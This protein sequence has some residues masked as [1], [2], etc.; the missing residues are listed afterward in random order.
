MKCLICYSTTDIK[1][2]LTTL[3][4]TIINGVD[5]EDCYN[6]VINNPYWNRADYPEAVINIIEL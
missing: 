2:N 4:N 6:K 3:H 1:N 5:K